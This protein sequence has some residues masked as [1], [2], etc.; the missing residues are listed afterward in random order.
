MVFV[1]CAIWAF[2]SALT[3]SDDG[4]DYK[5]LFSDW[6]RGEWKKIKFPSRDTVFDYYLDPETNVFDQWTKSPYFYTVA[7]D[8]KTT[9][10]TQVCLNNR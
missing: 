5:K 9:P 4:T 6:W 10:M 7:Y 2:G 1:Y 8:S 3:V